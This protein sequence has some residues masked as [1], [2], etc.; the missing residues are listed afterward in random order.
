PSS[1]NLRAG[2]IA[3]VTVYALRR[4]GFTGE[5]ALQLKDAP[6]GFALQGGVIPA[7]EDRVRFTLTAPPRR[8]DAPVAIQLEGRAT[9]AGGEVRHTAVAAEDMMQAFAY[10]HLV[11][12][13][14]WF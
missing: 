12:A 10:H 5:I 4:D 6:L 2:G 8:E 1:L 3:P 11:S 7:G 9:I 13:A 14:G